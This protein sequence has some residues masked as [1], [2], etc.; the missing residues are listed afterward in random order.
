M[1]HQL[2]TID[3][4]QWLS[5]FLVSELFTL[6]K[7]IEDFK[8]FVFLWLYLLVFAILKIEPLKIFEGG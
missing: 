2:A 1:S 5:H 4:E 7:I 6:L 8:E 3:L